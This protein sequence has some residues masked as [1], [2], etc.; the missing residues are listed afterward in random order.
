MTNQQHLKNR[1]AKLLSSNEAH[2]PFRDA[3]NELS[4]DDCILKPHGF[5][6]SIYDLVFHCKV[7]QRDILQYVKN[8][9]HISPEWPSGYW[10]EKNHTPN[11]QIWQDNVEGFLSD[12]KEM[13]SIINNPETDLFEIYANGSGHDL[14]REVMVLCDHNA[15]HVG[16]I[17]LIRK[18]RNL[19]NN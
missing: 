8:P 19:W 9:H 10:P 11:A 7:T 15:Y 18:I 13:I 1:L 6:Y 12:Q 16:Q 5:P 14:F 17:V 3:I 4:F 2:V